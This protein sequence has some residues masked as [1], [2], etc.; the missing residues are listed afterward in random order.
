MVKLKTQ[1]NIV[2]FAIVHNIMYYILD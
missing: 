1:K 2:S